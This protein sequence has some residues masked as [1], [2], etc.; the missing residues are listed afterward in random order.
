M[1]EPRR[2]RR[3]DETRTLILDAAEEALRARPYRDLSL[4]GLMEQIGYR[5]TV[6]YRHFTGLPDLVLA[7]FSRQLADMQAAALTFE[8]DAL[9]SRIGPDAARELLRP[10]VE[11]WRRNGRLM[12]AVRDAAIHD[13]FMERLVAMTDDRMRATIISALTSQREHGALQHA[14]LEAVATLLAAMTQR[15]LQLV[16][17]EREEPPELDRV[18]DTLA[19]GW[20]SII[21]AP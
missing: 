5:R 12:L 14:D 21:N 20:V 16:Y 19:L 3:G 11:Q 2:R 15:Y 9:E 4:N 10:I 6:F 8:A 17:G 18:L 13:G 1:P 7:V